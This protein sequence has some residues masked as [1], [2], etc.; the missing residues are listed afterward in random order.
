M[1]VSVYGVFPAGCRG[2]EIRA[3]KCC[4]EEDEAVRL[5][6]EHWRETGKS[7]LIAEYSGDTSTRRER[8]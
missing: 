3:I 5:A 1:K 2:E 6:N 7:A 4:I 8:K